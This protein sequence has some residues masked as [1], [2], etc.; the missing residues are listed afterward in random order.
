MPSLG[1]DMTGDHGD[2][3]MD[4]GNQSAP[5]TPHTYHSPYSWN[6]FDLAKVFISSFFSSL[7]KLLN[8]FLILT[9]YVN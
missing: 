8:K 6:V 5:T 7:L 9:Y 3:G 2:H 1:P 4:K